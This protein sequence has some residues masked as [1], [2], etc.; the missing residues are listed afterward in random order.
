M[1]IR[2]AP[3]RVRRAHL[4]QDPAVTGRVGTVVQSTE[5]DIH[6]VNVALDGDTELRAFDPAELEAIEVP[7]PGEEREE[8]KRRR[9]LP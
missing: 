6:L 4:P 8:A 3:F 7:A 9:A 2:I 5:Y 1:A